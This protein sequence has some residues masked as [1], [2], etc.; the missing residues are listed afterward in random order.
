[1]IWFKKYK[2]KLIILLIIISVII[3]TFLNFNKLPKNNFNIIKVIQGDI[4]QNIL[5][6][7][8]IDALY[9]SDIHTQ[10]NGQLK[11]LYVKLGDKVKKGQLLG[12]IDSKQAKNN[13]LE[14]K[15]ILSELYAQLLQAKSEQKLAE[16]TLSRNKKLFKLQLIS[17]QD[18]D[19]SIT[20]FVIKT[21][22]VRIINAQIIKN[23]ISLN[24][25]K[26]KLSYTHITA[27]INGD[28]VQINI[29]PGQ[30]IFNTQQIPSILT[31]ANLKIMLIKAQVSEADVIHLKS[32]QKVW[33]T[34]LGNP[35]YHY[36]GILKNIEPT[37]KKINNAIFYD[38]CFQIENKNELLRLQMTA[39]VH[40]Q[41]DGV[42]N[43]NI[44]PLIALEDYIS[45][46]H[47][48][49]SIL[50]YGNIEKR[51]VTIG[52]RDNINVEIINGVKLGEEV[53]INNNI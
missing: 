5:A 39:Q 32:G 8:Q 45:D 10:I 40:I 21:V 28:V 14:K 53:I 20:Q 18:L 49:I 25:E 47:Y 36:Y 6:N 12:I 35:N 1:M 48:Y 51:E 24:T 50:K 31:L 3:I 19:H 52:L 26:I 2:Y 44:L 7:G 30:M 17:H 29:L 13:I 9:K 16:T 42:K 43:V 11:K 23:K 34:I 4:Q 38:A 22:Q 33:F 15:A 46:N 27:P 41:L 37:P